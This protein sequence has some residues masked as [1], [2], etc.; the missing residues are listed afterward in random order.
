ML[1]QT[2]PELLDALRDTLALTFGRETI[3]VQCWHSGGGCMVLTVDLSL[4]GRGLGR[5]VWLT[6]EEDWIFGVYDFALDPED[7]GVCVSLL[8][9]LDERENPLRVAAKVAALLSRLGVTK[10]QG[11]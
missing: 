5:Q 6:R 1:D 11:E 8:T 3:D 10:L 2:S 4:D 7:E 9:T